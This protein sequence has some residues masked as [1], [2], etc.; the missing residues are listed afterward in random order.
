MRRLVLA[1]AFAA[2]LLAALGVGK[3]AADTFYGYTSP[4]TWFSSGQGYGSVYDNICSRWSENHFSKGGSAWGLIT[5]IDSG[6]G[7]H[8]SM[9]GF[10]WIHRAPSSLNWTKKLH[11][12]NNSGVGYQGGCFGYRHA[13]QCA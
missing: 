12:G 11:C 8:D 6:G 9:Q 5:F 3:G 7:W 4:G 1:L 10:G 2:L 13:Y